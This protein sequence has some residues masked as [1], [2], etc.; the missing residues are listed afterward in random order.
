MS[1]MFLYGCD[2]GCVQN[3][4]NTELFLKK[5]SNAYKDE[6]LG[7]KNKNSTLFL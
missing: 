3:N 7:Q 5:G 4:S 6:Q 2:G 1:G